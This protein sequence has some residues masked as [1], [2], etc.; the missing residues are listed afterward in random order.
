LL[1]LWTVFLH[2]RSS[3]SRG[4]TNDNADDELI[5]DDDYLRC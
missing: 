5:D 1:Q 3:C 2:V 4:S